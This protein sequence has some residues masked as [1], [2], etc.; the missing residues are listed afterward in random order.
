MKKRLLATLLILIM[1]SMFAVSA[2]AAKEKPVELIIGGVTSMNAKDAVTK[3]I[4]LV[5]DYSGGTIVCKDFPDNQLG[6]DEQRWEMTQTG[7]CDIS[8]GSTSSVASSYND[9]Y[10]FDTPYLFLSRD[11]VF[12]VGFAGKAGQAILNGVESLNL[13]GLALWENGFRNVT[14]NNKEINTVADLK[15][16]KL[17]T[18]DNAIHLAAWKAMGANPTPMAFSEV[19]TALQQGT[20]DGQENPYGIIVGN[21]FEEV[22][23]FAAET[24]HSFTPYYVVMNLDR[25]NSLTAEQQDAITRAMSEAT[26]YEREQS[27]KYEAEDVATIEAAGCKVVKLSDDVLAEF[28]AA[29]DS[30]DCATMAMQK[31]EH[32]ELGQQ[33]IDTLAAARD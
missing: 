30:A 4:E 26:Q 5:E 24:R 17:R 15:G 1:V 3:F 12:D 10:I 2:E 19:F 27:E 13:K 31:M 8:I 7:E 29:A 14:T 21:K 28:K 23:K 6:N 22:E 16:L 9:F 18:M 33:L 25:W 11:E 32:P 20:V